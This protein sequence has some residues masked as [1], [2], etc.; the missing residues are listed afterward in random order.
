MKF[1]NLINKALVFPTF[2]ISTLFFTSSCNE[3]ESLE[4]EGKPVVSIEQKNITTTEGFG[5]SLKFDF[6]YVIKEAAQFR[7]E[8]VGGTAEEG[9]DYNFNLDTI[10]DAG[11]GYFGGEGYFAEI[12]NFQKTFELS[13]VLT[14]TNDGIND[15]GE[16][17]ILKISSVSKGTVLINETITITTEEFVPTTLDVLL[18]FD[19]SITIDGNSFNKCNLDFDLYLNDDE[20]SPYSGTTYFNYSACNELLSG[21]NAGGPLNNDVND[22]ADGTVYQ[23]WIDYWSAG[24]LPSVTNHENIPMNIVLTKVKDGVTT[25]LTLE[26]SELYKTNNVASED[27]PAEE[28]GLQNVATVKITGNTY[29]ITNKITGEETIF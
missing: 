13:D 25:T 17:I 14:V 7:I 10:E 22:W 20:S 27:D 28:S 11:F 21:G 15:P 26:F 8:V 9:V 18:D 3:D 29:L 16:T 24:S 5:T 12:P 6:S 4:R 23:I 2:C 1:N 19:G